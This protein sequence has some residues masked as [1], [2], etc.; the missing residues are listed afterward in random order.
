MV[1]VISHCVFNKIWPQLLVKQQY[2]TSTSPTI[3]SSTRPCHTMNFL[4]PAMAEGVAGVRARD[5]AGGDWDSE[6]EVFRSI[7]PTCHRLDQKKQ[8]KPQERQKERRTIIY[9]RPN[10][11]KPSR[12]KDNRRDWRSRELRSTS[13]ACRL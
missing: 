6:R 12:N 7:R 3:I 13:S 10:K 4:P 5:V 8:E 2:T 11:T 1:L 9:K